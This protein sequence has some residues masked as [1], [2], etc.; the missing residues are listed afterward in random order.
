MIGLDLEVGQVELVDDSSLLSLSFL[1]L[2]RLGWNILL[3]RLILL[4]VFGSLPD[5]GLLVLGWRLGLG[6]L[7][8]LLLPLGLS[9]RRNWGFRLSIADGGSCLGSMTTTWSRIT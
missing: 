6:L 8:L 2:T 3:R 1:L 9:L 5:L 7:D 4:D